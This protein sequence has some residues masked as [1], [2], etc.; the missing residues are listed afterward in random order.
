MGLFLETIITEC[1]DLNLVKQSISEISKMF[2][3]FEVNESKCRYLDR[4]GKGIQI[5]LNE[6]NVT[7]DK[8]SEQLSEKLNTWLM[9]LYIYDEDFWGYFL[10]DK[11]KEIDRFSPEPDY[12]G[13]DEEPKTYSGN[14][15]IVSRYF[16]VAKESIEKYLT[17]WTSEQYDEGDIFAYE[18]DEFAYADCWQ[19]SDF[20][21]KLGFPYGWD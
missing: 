3:G 11:G 14:A 19:M 16:G 13:E 5:L 21:D 8:F 6:G 10:Y 20:M 1:G 12:F 2:P 17:P 9:F 15:E 4:P 7:F 18:G